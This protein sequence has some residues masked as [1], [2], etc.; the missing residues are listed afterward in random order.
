MSYAI[1]RSDIKFL[2]ARG[3]EAKLLQDADSVVIQFRGSKADQF[4]KA[5]PVLPCTCRGVLVN[6]HK[7]LGAKSD[8]LLCRV[9]VEVNLQVRD[10]IKETQSA[11]ALAGQNPENVGSH[12]LRSGGATALFKAGFDS[13]AVKLFERWKSD[14]VERHTRISGQLTS[15]MASAMLAK[16]ALQLS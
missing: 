8:S 5:K 11:A 1:Q 15:R 3:S 4:G 13:L 10:V 6:H 9:D 16:S 2:D 14:A 12:S 7:S